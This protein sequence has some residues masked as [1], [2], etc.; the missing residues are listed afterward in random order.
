MEVAVRGNCLS[1]WVE[2]NSNSFIMSVKNGRLEGERWHVITF[3][4]PTPPSIHLFSQ[5]H[6]HTHKPKHT[7]EHMAFPWLQWSMEQS[8]FQL[9]YSWE[10]LMD[11]NCITRRHQ[12]QRESPNLAKAEQKWNFDLTEG[13]IILYWQSGGYLSLHPSLFRF[14]LI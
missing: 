14:L 8:S 13:G 7:R 1:E 10:K 5:S 4:C 2:Y 6:S 11:L 12:G 3:L 9:L